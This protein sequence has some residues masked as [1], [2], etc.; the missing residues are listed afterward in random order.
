MIAIISTNTFLTLYGSIEEV[1]NFKRTNLGVTLALVSTNFRVVVNVISE[2]IMK[3]DTIEFH[4]FCLGVGV[5]LLALA[6]SLSG[7]SFKKNQFWF[8]PLL[9]WNKL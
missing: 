4:H 1:T 7:P 2:D 8:L 5:P 9:I 6:L 3:N